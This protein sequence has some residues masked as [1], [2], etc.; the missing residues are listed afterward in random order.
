M[1]EVTSGLSPL[2]LEPFGRLVVVSPH[3]D[4]ETL[5]CGGLVATTAETAVP[6]V[7]LVVTDGELAGPQENLAEIR[8]G[9]LR[10]ALTALCGLERVTVHFL[11]RPDGGVAGHLEF[12]RSAVADVIGRGD[13]VVCPLIDDGH[14]DHEAVSRATAI[15]ARETA[16]RLLTFPVWAWHCHDPKSSRIGRGR[17]ARPRRIRP[18]TQAH[19][20]R[21]IRVPARRRRPRRSGLD[22]AAPGP[23]LRGV[24]RAGCACTVRSFLEEFDPGFRGVGGRVRPGPRSCG[25]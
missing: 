9:E 18:T 10:A 17:R 4:D 11:E 12:V 23:G 21:A 13:L 24:R 5:G 22:V 2:T 16:A 25:R 7:V 6:V 8:R 19:R 14:P 3:P 15:A 20:H 1:G